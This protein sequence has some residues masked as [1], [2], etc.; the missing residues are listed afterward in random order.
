M[1]SNIINVRFSEVREKFPGFHGLDKAKRIFTLMNVGGLDTFE[2]NSDVIVFYNV[3]EDSTPILVIERVENKAG[4][5]KKA[6]DAV[7]K[8]NKAVTGYIAEV[9]PVKKTD[10]YF[11]I[12]VVRRSLHDQIGS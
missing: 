3:M 8:F 7:M 4:Q 2:D 11:D 5:V 12:K 10:P 9:Q 1:Y 6:K